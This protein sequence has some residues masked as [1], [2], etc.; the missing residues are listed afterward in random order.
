MKFSS[1]QRISI[2]ASAV[3]AVMLFLILMPSPM[4]VDSGVV[5]RGGLQVTLDGE[6][7]SRVRD[8]YIVASPVNG[9]LERIS[10][11]EGD[12]VLPG[13]I[14]ARI[15]PP[16]LNSREYENA[17]AR[18]KSAEALLEAANAEQRRVKLD[19][20]RAA[21][22]HARYRNLYAKGAVSSETYEEVNTAWEVAGKRYQAAR[23]N[24][25]SASYERDAARSV[26]DRSIEGRPFDV[27]APDSGKVLRVFEKS[28]RVV[29]A[30][31]PLVEIGDPGDIEVVVDLLSSE[32]VKVEPGMVVA[33]EEWGGGA[34]LR[35]V[36]RTVEPAAFTK[37]SALGI[38]EKRVN[39]VV[40]LSET[41]PA[42]GDNYRIQARI[43]L[44]EGEN[45]LKVPVSAVFRGEEGWRVFALDGGRAVMRNVKLGRIGTYDA[46]VLEGLS[47]GD[48]VVVHPTNDL[49][50]G[51]RVKAMKK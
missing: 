16:P 11:E 28:E 12:G 51:M 47:E 40:D 37:I 18:A 22:K 20:D 8:S 35:G 17:D 48:G 31:T 24:A 32:A 19:L 38:E 10:L 25:E 41:R 26:I 7:V 23:L 2:I 39:I 6:G 50:D 27:K 5:S 34:A 33:V 44:W 36:V 29:A 30:G 45:I 1:T 9:R 42:L 49:E 14:V 21:T 15:T 4:Q 3:V 43:V 46:E 13:Q